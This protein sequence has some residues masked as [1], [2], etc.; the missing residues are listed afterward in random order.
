MVHND[1]IPMPPGFGQQPR[2]IATIQPSGTIF[3]PPAPM[4]IPNLDALPPGQKAEMYSFDHD[5]GQ[6]VSIGPGTV[7]DDGLSLCSDPGIGLLKGGWHCGGNPQPTGNCC[8][9]PDCK[10]CQGASCVNDSGQDGQMVG[11][12][13]CF[14]GELISKTQG[15]IA[16]LQN[17][18]PARTQNTRQHDIDGCSLPGILAVL[19]PGLSV[20]DPTGGGCGLTDTTFGQAQGTIGSAAAALPLPCNQHDICYQTCRSTQANCDSG[21]RTRMDAVCQTAYP[22][23][24]CPYSGFELWKCIIG[25]A[26]F[27]SGL[28]TYATER[29]QCFGWSATYKFGLDQFGASAWEERQTQYCDCC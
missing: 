24:I 17:K 12:Q 6:F 23:A 9:C 20:N 11:N 4:C 13:C 8:E 3:D 21:M 27:P 1:K 18:C 16:D 15:N 2:F 22:S 29:I 26:S 19:T 28:R 14:A 5:M 7:S 25:C 10:R